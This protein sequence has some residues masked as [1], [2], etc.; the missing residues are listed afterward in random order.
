[1]DAQVRARLIGAERLINS[2]RWRESNLKLVLLTRD[3]KA[4]IYARTWFLLALCERLLG[5]DDLADATHDKA[6][7]CSDY[8]AVHEGDFLRD[9]AIM[10]IKQGRYDQAT[11]CL[12]RVWRLH[13][14]NPN[15]MACIVMVNGCKLVRQ[16][17][18][19]KAYHS[20]VSAER[21]FRQLGKAANKQWRTNNR[22]HLMI[23]A[24]LSGRRASAWARL[25]RLLLTD[26]FARKAAGLSVCFGGRQAAL[27]ALEQY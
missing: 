2:G 25:P 26:R 16:G 27:K 24:V 9:K 17:R 15:R 14:N 8:D 21:S 19:E 10:F 23:A 22:L 6:K 1:M 5:K 7:L 11:D 3:P 13:T 18:A 12:T 4:N 20:H